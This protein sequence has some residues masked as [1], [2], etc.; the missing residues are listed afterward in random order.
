MNTAMIPTTNATVLMILSTMTTVADHLNFDID[1]AIFHAV[2]HAIE[3]NSQNNRINEVIEFDC[4][5]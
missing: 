4:C 1:R 3:Q 5:L 2:E